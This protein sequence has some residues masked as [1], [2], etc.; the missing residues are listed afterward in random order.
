MTEVLF[1][2]E[3]I[4]ISYAERRCIEEVGKII[5]DVMMMILRVI[6]ILMGKE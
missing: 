4:M 5:M 3:V 2:K 1:M 6:V